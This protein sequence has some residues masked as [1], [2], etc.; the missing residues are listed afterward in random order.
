MCEYVSW[1]WKQAM[2]FND[3]A[4]TLNA[5]VAA[6]PWARVSLKGPWDRLSDWQTLEP[7]TVHPP[8]PLAVLTGCMLI[9]WN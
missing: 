9:A 3:G 5:F 6:Y 2:P 1:L 8:M 7:T 4:E